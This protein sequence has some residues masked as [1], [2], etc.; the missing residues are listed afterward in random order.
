[1]IALLAFGDAVVGQQLTAMLGLG[2]P[3]TRELTAGLLARSIAD[4]VKE[5]EKDAR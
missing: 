1:M 2:R 5:A 3:A 4:A